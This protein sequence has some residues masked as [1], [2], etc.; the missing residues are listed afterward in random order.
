MSRKHTVVK[1]DTP[2]KL[3]IKYYGS[4]KKYIKIIEANPQIKGKNIYPGQILI[5]PDETENIIN[6]TQVKEPPLTIDSDNDDSISILIDNNKFSFFTDYSMTFN[7]DTFDTFS[8]SAPFDDSIEIYRDV[9]RPMS[10]KPAYI[11]Y[12]G[13]LIFTGTLLAPEPSVNPD[14]KTIS[15]SG[16]SKPGILNDC[17]MPITSFPLEFNNQTI[18][19]I[20]D[21]ICKPYGIQNRFLVS[22]GNPFEKI[23]FEIEKKIFSF[24]SD[25]ANQRGMLITNDKMGK[26]VFWLSELGNPIGNFKEG[27]L[28]FISCSPS[29][30]YQNFF[31]HITGVTTT[32]EDKNSESYTYTNNYL[33]K[34]G[35]M[36]SYN[37]TAEDMKDSEIKSTVLS[38]AG[39]MFGNSVTYNLLIY[40]HKNAKGE[41][42]QKNNSIT[43]QSPGA[44]IY[45]DTE[46]LIKSFTMKRTNEGDT[47]EF[48]LV[49]PGAYTGELPEVFP[50]EE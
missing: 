21:I 8:F 2:Y 16:Y 4:G 37:F 12:S 39:Y 25:L 33:I 30:D 48:T 28:P 44:M 50:W 18:K 43:L 1:G 46:F 9:F 11:Y 22:P 15:I 40:G 3:S 34:Q 17:N 29:F 35:T 10:F 41:L 6:H 31:S 13:D 36:R 42:F 26:L 32:K 49:L 23:S 5:I 27:E 20:A 47:T 38:K 24:L 45:R 14:A 7:I 19:Q